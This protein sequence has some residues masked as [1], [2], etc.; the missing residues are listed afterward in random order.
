[1]RSIPTKTRG[2]A[3][4]GAQAQGEQSQ[5]GQVE[6]APNDGAQHAGLPDGCMR[7]PTAD[8][9]LSDE[10]GAE[11]DHLSD[12]NDDEGEH[13]GFGGQEHASIGHGG[14]TGPDRP[15]PVFRADGQHAQNPDGELAE[16]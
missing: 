4:D 11:G 1:M 2:V 5:Q 9:H 7:G 10:E 16:E 14:E 15:G 3:D 12:D 6:A 13:G 8:Q